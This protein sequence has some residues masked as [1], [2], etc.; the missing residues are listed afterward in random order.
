MRDERVFLPVEEY[1]RG[2]ENEELFDWHLFGAML[3][4]RR[5]KMG[6][7]KASAFSET[8]Y[9]RTRLIITEQQ[10]YKIESGRRVPTG[11]ELVAIAVTVGRGA[12]L[13]MLSTCSCDEWSGEWENGEVPKHWR[14][15][16]SE[17]YALAALGHRDLHCDEWAAIMNQTSDQADMIDECTDCLY[18]FPSELSS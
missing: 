11:M 14:I 12:F 16:N 10:L 18:P 9:N 5:L 2:K 8:I 17:H 1:D 15:E 7:K 6:Y 13:Q 4:N 3:R